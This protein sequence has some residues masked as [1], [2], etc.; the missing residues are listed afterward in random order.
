MGAYVKSI[1]PDKLEE[2]AKALQAVDAKYELLLRFGIETGLRVSDCLALRVGEFKK[3]MSL[4]ERKT[5][6]RR[7]VTIS[8]KLLEL[9]QKHIKTHQ[10]R[11]T[12]AL[13]F[14]LPSRRW[15]PLSRVQ[16]WSVFRRMAAEIG[17]ESVGPHS[18]RKMYAMNVLQET[19]DLKAVQYALAHKHTETTLRYLLDIKAFSEMAVQG[20]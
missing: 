14:S 18:M 13:F 15:K 17:L 6:K 12:D 16:A 10:L 2:F 4:F 8:D 19:G 1:P 3:R 5:N 20:L 9:G 11:P 7:E